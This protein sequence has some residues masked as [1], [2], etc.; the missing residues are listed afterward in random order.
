VSLLARVRGLY[1]LR[2]RCLSP[3]AF[4]TDFGWHECS[5]F[6]T[7]P[8]QIENTEPGSYVA[9]LQ[10]AWATVGKHGHVS[11]GD[12]IE[13]HAEELGDQLQVELHDSRGLLAAGTIPISCL[14]E[15]GLY[16]LHGGSHWLQ[17]CRCTGFQH[18]CRSRCVSM[19]HRNVCMLACCLP[20]HVVALTQDAE[21]EL[22]RPSAANAS[23]HKHSVL[24]WLRRSNTTA[25][26]GEHSSHHRASRGTRESLQLYDAE[27]HNEAV[28][29]VWVT[30]WMGSSDL[31]AADAVAEAAQVLTLPRH[32]CD[33]WAIS[34]HARMGH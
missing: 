27:Q 13:L 16:T 22:Q 17:K 24:G 9:E 30:A 33:A 11:G 20:G 32:M 23:Q 21:T 15:V 4:A 5:R 7:C 10:A 34:M 28:G 1:V 3:A 19:L 2:C 8:T 25:A 6:L 18:V 26:S 14:W 29:S 31:E 12:V